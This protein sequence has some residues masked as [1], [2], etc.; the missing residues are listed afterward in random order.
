MKIAEFMADAVN[1]NP[2]ERQRLFTLYR[3]TGISKRYSVLEDFGLERGEYK[4]FP[5]TPDM[6]PFPTVATRMELYRK[7][8]IKL[9]A[10]AVKDCITESQY[11]SVTHLITVSCTG[12]YAPGIDLDLVE[13]L[14]LNSTTKRTCINYMG[15]YAAF[16]ALKIADNICRSDQ[17]AKVLIVC[18][19]L[20]TIHYQKSKD[21]DHLLSNAIFS[22]GAAAVLMENTSS[23]N[24]GLCPEV[25]HCDIVFQGKRDMAWQISNFGFEMTL[26][27]YVPSMI[28]GGISKLTYGALQKANINMDEI[29][30]F[31]IHP[32]G[33]KII[34][35]VED[36]LDIPKDKTSHSHMVLREY[37]NMSS[38]SILFVLKKILDRGIDLQGKKI[39]AFAFGPG[40][41]IESVVLSACLNPAIQNSDN[42][43]QYA[44]LPQ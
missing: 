35:A 11:E 3:A 1:M 33:K 8:A 23:T 38:P 9:A 36:A 13:H 12:M 2:E 40:L 30:F 28:E 20:C 24:V 32:G 19:E 29:S 27:S 16:N 18:V 34:E 37:G 42:K 39:M 43:T 26:S 6:E 10:N 31:A 17:D 4:F 15:C 14:G 41:T 25:F 22:D 5:N 21:W 7:E 44:I